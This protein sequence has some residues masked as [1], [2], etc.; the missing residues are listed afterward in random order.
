MPRIGRCSGRGCL[1]TVVA[2]ALGVAACGGTGKTSPSAPAGT[3]GTSATTSTQTTSASTSGPPA[4]RRRP[5][6]RGAPV[7]ATQRVHAG[8]SLLDV[9][10]SKV[11]D[12][13]T[14]TGAALLPGTRAA[15]VQV[16]IRNAGGATY[17][18]TASGDWSLLTTAGLTSPLFVRHGVCETPLADFESLIGVGETRSGCVAFS[19]PRRARILSVRFSPHSRARG[20]VAWR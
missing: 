4:R 14:A 15:G 11:L 10:V 1:L 18:S 17:D 9:T 13:L 3:T 19:V 20:T 12:P 16:A 7:G 6:P 5:R 8:G 2:L